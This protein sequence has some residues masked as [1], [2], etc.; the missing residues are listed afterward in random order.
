MLATLL[1]CGVEHNSVRWNN[2]PPIRCPLVQDEGEILQRTDL[3]EC[4][5]LDTLDLDF[6]AL[7]NS[8]AARTCGGGTGASQ[9]DEAFFRVFAAAAD[10]ELLGHP[11]LIRR[12]RAV[13]FT[14]RLI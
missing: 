3:I 12:I 1:F 7:E 9:R 10:S 8:V 14:V 6:L 11:G 5:L 4:R 13:S 2:E